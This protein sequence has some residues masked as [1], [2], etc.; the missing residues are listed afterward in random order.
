MPHMEAQFGNA[1]YQGVP[2]SE[3]IK[4]AEPKYHQQEHGNSA[5]TT[6]WPRGKMAIAR[7]SPLRSSNP[8]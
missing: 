1:S 5:T 6:L 2:I 4:L 3:L 7:S 8:I